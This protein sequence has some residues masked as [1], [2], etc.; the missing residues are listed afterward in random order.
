MGVNFGFEVQIDEL[1]R[2][3]NAGVHRTGAIYGFK[4]PDAPSATRPVGEWN[5]YEITVDGPDLTVAL[6]G[7]VVN[8]FHFTGD[9]QSPR[10]GLPSTPQDPRYIGVR[11]T[12][13]GSFSVTSNGEP[14]DTMGLQLLPL[15]DL[16]AIEVN[17][18]RDVRPLAAMGF[19]RRRQR[20][21]GQD[22]PRGRPV[23]AGR[24]STG[25]PA[26]AQCARSLWRFLVWHGAD[27]RD[28]A[29]RRG[30]SLGH[31]GRYVYR[32]TSRTR[33]S[34]RSTGSSIL[35]PANS[36][37]AS[38]QPSRWVTSLTYGVLPRHSG[39]PRHSPT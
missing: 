14:C 18:I 22:H 26:G 37:S 25:I 21:V 13:G 35:L 31:A 30:L 1:A 29:G 20:G 32:Y 33:M 36:G 34:A 38:S 23:S 19:S 4:A 8:Q 12:R 10:R 9:P 3:D 27:R 17:G 28:P 7:H 15:S 24:A 2:P 11:R 5:D 16:G 39:E 6:N